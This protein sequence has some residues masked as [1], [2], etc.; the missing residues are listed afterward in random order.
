MKMKTHCPQCAEL[1]KCQAAKCRFCGFDIDYNQRLNSGFPARRILYLM[2]LASFVVSGMDLAGATAGSPRQ[3][4]GYIL[5]ILF[6]LLM[7]AGVIVQVAQRKAG[8]KRSDK[9][10]WAISIA[11]MLVLLFAGMV[12][13][14]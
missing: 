14:D 6:V 13:I 5:T 1:I 4:E 7:T 12:A 2:A 9:R 3:T 11:L 10:F 8:D